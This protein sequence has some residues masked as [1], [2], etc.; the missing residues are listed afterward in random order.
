MNY[1]IA[2]CKRC[3]RE[4]PIY[5]KGLCHHCYWGYKM[6]KKSFMNKTKSSEG[7]SEADIFNEIWNEREHVSYISHE[8]L[9]SVKPHSSFWYNLFAHVLPKGRY[10][11]MKFVKENIVLLTPYEHH[12]FDYSTSQDRKKYAKEMANKGVFVDW[13]KL[14]SLKEKLLSK[15]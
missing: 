14:Y 3:N 2:I 9:K 6:P 1:K 13:D 7:K 10:K 15:I 4:R 12:L 11:D 8:S 5:A